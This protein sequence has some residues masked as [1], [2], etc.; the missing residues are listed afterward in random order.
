[1]TDKDEESQ[2]WLS[3]PLDNAG[4]EG[5]TPDTTAPLPE[6]PSATA[7]Q[8][9]AF[10]FRGNGKEYFKI[11]I[12]NLALTIATVGIYSPWAKVRNLRYF[13]GN[14]Y[15]DGSS[16]EFLGSPVAILK[17][18][19]IAVLAFGAY[20][21]AANFYPFANLF[22]IPIFA[23][24]F[25]WVFVKTLTFRSRNSAYRN[26]TFSYYGSYRQIAVAYLG[27]PL[28]IVG[29]MA[30]AFM[31]SGLPIQMPGNVPMQLSPAVGAT[32]GI[33]FAV[34]VLGVSLLFPYFY[35]LQKRVFA[36]PRNFGDTP[37]VFAAG[38]RDFY[39]LVFK[40]SLLS[41]LAVVAVLAAMGVAGVF[42]K[43]KAAAASHGMLYVSILSIF[44]FGLF[45]L[46]LFVAFK[47]WTRNLVLS[48]VRIG[49]AQVTSRL[50]VLDVFFLYFTNIIAVIC[51]LGLLIP[52]AKVRLARYQMGKTSLTS[53]EGTENFSG[54]PGASASAVGEEL[55]DFFDLDLA[56]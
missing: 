3:N 28:L 39:R 10:E 34:A 19:I 24:L 23:L 4:V 7:P 31:V 27:L 29:A 21:V 32:A 37:F 52:W 11:W 53:P 54:S 30:A 6:K 46:L 14:T 56:I 55:A 43:G 1:M 45:Q 50:R 2:A 5:G 13:Y 15:L 9:I 26:L 47:T 22:L 17:G 36:E 33:V 40:L 44:G 25:P 51:T 16:F 35:F 42:T 38:P 12:V 48:A 18:R 41:I 20:W 8:P 49:E